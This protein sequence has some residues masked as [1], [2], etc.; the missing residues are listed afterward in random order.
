MDGYKGEDGG[1]VILHSGDRSGDCHE[2]KKKT[3]EREQIHIIVAYVNI[4]LTLVKAD[5]VLL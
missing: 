1:K 3:V 4:S 5:M 2:R